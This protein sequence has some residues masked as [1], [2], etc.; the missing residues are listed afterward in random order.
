MIDLLTNSINL[1][2]TE[3]LNDELKGLNFAYPAKQYFTNPSIRKAFDEGAFIVDNDDKIYHLKQ[4]D[5]KLILKYTNIIKPDIIN[6]IISEDLRREFYGLIVTKNDTG[7]I[8]YDYNIIDLN[9]SQYDPFNANLNFN[10]S[11]VDKIVTITTKDN[12]YTKVMDLN[13]AKINEN[14]FKLDKLQSKRYIKAYF[15][16]FELKISQPSYFYKFEFVNFSKMGFCLSILMA[17][18]YFAYRLK[19]NSQRDI[20]GTAVVVI[21]GLY[22]LI[23]T[24]F[25]KE[26]A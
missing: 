22:G 16:P 10:I 14:D 20:Y 12:I 2:K 5:G 1:E 24:I 23:S 9:L 26:K 13:Y 6:I 17:I 11:P 18:L 21:F 4:I 19:F 7:L 25:F 3:K 8:D 15:L